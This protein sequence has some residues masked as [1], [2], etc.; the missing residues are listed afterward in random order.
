MN[1]RVDDHDLTKTSLSRRLTL[2]IAPILLSISLIAGY[3]VGLYSQ[4]LEYQRLTESRQDQTDNITLLITDQVSYYQYHVAS[5]IAETLRRAGEVTALEFI[6]NDDVRRVAVGDTDDRQTATTSIELLNRQ[7]SFVGTLY[8]WFPEI[9]VVLD[10]RWVV[11]PLSSAALL[12]LCLVAAMAFIWRKQVGTPLNLIYNAMRQ[13]RGGREV[14]VSLQRDDE[15]GYIADNYN[16]MLDRLQE[17]RREIEAMAHYDHLTGASSQAY[18]IQRLET[19]INSKNTQSYE[20][21]FIDIN[22]FKWINDTYGHSAGDLVIK[23]FYERIKAALPPDTLISRF[24]GDEFVFVI[25][26]SE[27]DHQSV[28]A[29]IQLAQSAEFKIKGDIGLKLTASIGHANYPQ[30]AGD[31]ELLLQKADAAMYINKRLSGNWNNLDA[32]TQYSSLNRENQQIFAILQHGNFEDVVTIE[33]QPIINID[34]N[35]LSALEA[36]LRLHIDGKVIRNISTETIIHLAEKSGL[37]KNIDRQVRHAVY[38]QIQQ[39]MAAGISTPPVHLNISPAL[40]SASHFKQE[41][42]KDTEQ[43]GLKNRKIVLEITETVAVST[44][45]LPLIQSLRQSGFQVALDDFGKGYSSLSTLAKLPIDILKLD[46]EFFQCTEDQKETIALIRCV[47][48]MANAVGCRLIAEG[49]EHKQ[50]HEAL[51]ALNCQYV[52]GNYYDFP[53]SADDIKTKYFT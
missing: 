34:T 17:H 27:L 52:Q 35:E 36:L 15:L 50:I 32:T 18:F 41:L 14:R 45:A 46:K 20:L 47:V 44:D 49:V 11:I 19:L 26:T 7:Q 25:P 28:I 13:T 23:A 9:D 40:L 1:T 31:F 4:K 33:Y 37:I 22:R 48:D 8:L 43:F 29:K 16:R 21:Y 30:D 51:V 39:W 6:D 24:G 12:L 10:W 53:M 42:I 38:T 5:G 3:L 2:I